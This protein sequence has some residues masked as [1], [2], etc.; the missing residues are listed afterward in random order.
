MSSITE[1][2]KEAGVSPA[3][4]SRTF[5]EPSLL[6]H[7]TRRR[8]LEAASRLD[9]RPRRSR[10]SQPAP[11][12]RTSPAFHHADALGFLFFALDSD[13]I[14][15]SEC[16]SPIL[17]GAQAEAAR[18]GLHLVV[19]NMSRLRPT[20]S[21]PKMLR[22]NA[23][24]G[25][26][27]VGAA[28]DNVLDPLGGVLPLVLVDNKDGRCHYD[29]IMSDGFGGAL[30]ATRYLLDM[31]HRRIGFVM[32]EPSAPSFQDRYRGYLSALFDAGVSADRSWIV[33]AEPGQAI[34]SSLRGALQGG[35]RPTAL[36]AASDLNALHAMKACREMGLEIPAD[37]SIVGFDDIPS[38][39]HTSP[40][41]TTVR[42]DKEYIGRLAV[43]CLR[44]RIQEKA[45][46]VSPGLPIHISVPTTM[47]VRESC[48]HMCSM[49]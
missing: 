10:P 48:S 24:A 1:V 13:A 42:V 49:S 7:Q 25:A 29:T 35:N 26:L 47:I 21:L 3:T 39:V 5:R 38:A 2:A 36:V 44:S 15:I 22:E 6:S 18:N 9:Y 16:Y 27:L 4:V 12:S 20:D 45:E 11:A 14:D 30:A 43:R 28:P 19:D 37:L 17:L 40:S 46:G 23:V 41:L 31:G 8:V 32:Y 33:S 34:E